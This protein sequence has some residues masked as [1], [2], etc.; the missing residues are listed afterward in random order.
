MAMRPG[1]RGF[2]L[3]EVMVTLAVMLILLMAAIPMSISWSNSAKQRDAAGLLQ[4][5]LSR[6]KALALRNPGAVAAGQPSVALCLGGDT[7]SLLRLERDAAFS[8]TPAGAADLQWSALVPSSAS[9]RI[10]GADFKCL[11]LDNRGLPVPVSDCVAGSTGTF[12]VVVGSEDPL[13][14]TLI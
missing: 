2:T 11:A 12:N 13:D 5:G 6:A 3:I 1:A 7:L 4:Q 9:I 14:V 10:G 8:C